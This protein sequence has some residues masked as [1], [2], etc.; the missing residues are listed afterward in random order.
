MKRRRLTRPVSSSVSACRRTTWCRRAFSS[1][2]AAWE[3]SH[4]ASAVAS[5]ESPPAGGSTMSR[6]SPPL[7]D[8]PRSSSSGCSP[9]ASPT[10]ASSRSSSST[11]PPAAPVA[12]T[13]MSRITGRSPLVSCVAASAFPTS[14]IAS[15]GSRGGE[16]P[17]LVAGRGSPRRRARSSSRPKTMRRPSVTNVATTANEKSTGSISSPPRSVLL[18]RIGSPQ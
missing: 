10:R 15:R 7:A 5:A 1:A 8:S 4:S 3:A 2:I 9:A 14:E 16:S 18:P 6:I 11:R 12:S 13:V 17:L